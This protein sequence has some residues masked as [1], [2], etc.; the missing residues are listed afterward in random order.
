VMTY[1][2]LATSAVVPSLLLMWYFHSRD[3]NREPGRVLWW[4]VRRARGLRRL[5]GSAESEL[6]PPSARLP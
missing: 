1:V 3:V 5:Q 2:L 6:N 4:T